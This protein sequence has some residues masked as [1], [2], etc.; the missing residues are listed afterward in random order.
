VQALQ[1]PP[2]CS[3]TVFLLYTAPQKLNTVTSLRERTAQ[4]A[5]SFK[6][7]DRFERCANSFF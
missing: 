7:S 6:L 2:L 1:D 5:R 4:N 3:S